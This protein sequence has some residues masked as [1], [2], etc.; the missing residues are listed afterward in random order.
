[1]ALQLGGAVVCSLRHLGEEFKGGLGF[2]DYW[3]WKILEDLKIR[4]SARF[5]G[6]DM[7]RKFSF[8]DL[9]QSY[10]PR[11]TCDYLLRNRPMHLRIFLL[12]AAITAAVVACS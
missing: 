4:I 9:R 7:P 6:L 10:G 5:F 12:L 8:F 2:G 1:M 11:K 3:D